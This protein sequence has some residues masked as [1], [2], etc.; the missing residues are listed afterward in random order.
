[1]KDEDNP[2]RMNISPHLCKKL[3]AQ[4][5]DGQKKRLQEESVSTFQ[6]SHLTQ[7]G[8]KRRERM[9]ICPKARFTSDDNASKFRMELIQTKEDENVFS[10]LNPNILNVKNNI[11]LPE[12]LKHVKN[13]KSKSTAK[14]YHEMNDHEKETYNLIK[15]LRRELT[16]DNL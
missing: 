10:R 16:A 11:D 3:N 4:Y 15:N 6:Q 7:G 5:E 1:M 13:K 14:K 8:S 9:N 12:Y 2:M